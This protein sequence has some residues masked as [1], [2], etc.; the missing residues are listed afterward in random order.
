MS[1]ELR[2]KI[3]EPTPGGVR[4]VVLLT[5]IVESYLIDGIR[6]VIDVGQPKIKGFHPITGTVSLFPYPMSKSS[7]KERA[8]QAGRRSPGKCFRLYT[9]NGFNNVM[10]DDI[11]PEIQVA[12]LTQAILTLKSLGLQHLICFDFMAWPPIEHLLEAVDLLYA[13][14][15][16]DEVG[17]ITEKGRKMAEF[18]VD[19]ILSKMIVA[20]EKYKCSAEIITIAAMLSV[21]S[22]VF[23][24]TTDHRG[25]V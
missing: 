18:P 22:S 24:S 25:E 5:D 23:Y 6:Y 1:S 11:V 19:P 2:K 3:F 21:G 12:E 15:A 8:D 4:K 17:K 13:L 16:V 10:E 7:A 9:E 14:D 20:S